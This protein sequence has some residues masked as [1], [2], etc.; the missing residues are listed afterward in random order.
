MKRIPVLR[1]F[2]P[3]VCPSLF[4]VGK[5]SLPSSTGNCVGQLDTSFRSLAASVR[6]SPLAREVLE[7]LEMG[8]LL[9]KG[10]PQATGL[11]LSPS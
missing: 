10:D 2:V 8:E 9:K 5:E 11:G 4:S 3:P 6:C 1:T 7:N